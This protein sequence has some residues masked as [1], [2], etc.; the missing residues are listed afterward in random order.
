MTI[1][2]HNINGVECAH[3][4]IYAHTVCSRYKNRALDT[5]ARSLRSLAIIT[6]LQHTIILQ[7]LQ[8]AKQ[9]LCVAL[10]VK[11]RGALLLLLSPQQKRDIEDK[12]PAQF[13][14][15]CCMPA[16]STSCH[17]EL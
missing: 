13:A 5:S 16:K 8:L 9:C 3:D 14:A 2:M 7:S 17:S 1:A 6:Q 10:A 12:N 4:E 11:F 15:D